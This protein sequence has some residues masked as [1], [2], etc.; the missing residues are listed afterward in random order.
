MKRIEKDEPIMFTKM[1][2]NKLRK[3]KEKYTK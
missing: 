2:P 3:F 1:K